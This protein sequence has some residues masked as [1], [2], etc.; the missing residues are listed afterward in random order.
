MKKII[1]SI[2]TITAFSIGVNAQIVNIP[3]ANF[4]AFLVATPTINT[5]SDTEIQVSEAT[6]YTGSMYCQLQN[7]SDLTGIEAFTA[8]TILK[9]S[10]NNLSSLNVTQNTSLQSLYCQNN[11]LTSLDV[12]Q[13][14]NL[15]YFYCYNNSISSL[16]VSQ[17]TN[18]IKLWC[19]DNQLIS[20]DVTQNTGLDKLK[21]HTNQL[22]SL[23]V[24]NGNNSSLTDFEATGNPN[25]TCIQVDNIAWST[26]NWGAPYSIDV[27][28][29]FSLNCSGSV[30][31]DEQANNIYLS[32]YPNPVTSQ[33]TLN[34]NE[35]TNSINIID[36]SG[37]V[38]K[39]I[40]I[41][42]DTTTNTID[43]SNLTKGIYFLQVQTENDIVSVKFIKE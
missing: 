3:D 37:K 27:G 39:T 18:L 2:I 31:I 19:F 36:I 34:T 21:C 25:L 29:S 10:D 43:V 38:V 6:A 30:G 12:I 23:N 26:T 35:K 16:D 13:N 8:L 40:P 33:L 20:L 22:T 11:Q 41:A 42:I 4:K 1:L 32:I 17:N 28:A 5:N 9:C 24:A 14:T 15:N 7:I